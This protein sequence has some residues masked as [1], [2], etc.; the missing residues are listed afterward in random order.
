[1]ATVAQPDSDTPAE[2]ANAVPEGAR[3]DDAAAVA[4]SPGALDEA[5][6]AAFEAER[7]RLFEK[8]YF[9]R[10]TIERLTFTWLGQRAR[11]RSVA[12]QNG[13][14]RPDA[15]MGF[16]AF[17]QD[18]FH[19]WICD[20]FG[21]TERDVAAIWVAQLRLESRHMESLRHRATAEAR[22]TAREIASAAGI[23]A[24]AGASA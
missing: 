22:A 1:M 21:L 24:A 4:P 10:D 16:W 13:T 9:E 14:R 20:R 3:G 17:E 23:A 7:D 15:F 6:R 12:V 8:A 11:A 19:R 18:R 2:Q 5:D